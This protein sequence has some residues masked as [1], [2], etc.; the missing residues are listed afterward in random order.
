ME[1]TTL[2]ETKEQVVAR[3]QQLAENT[4]LPEK[5]EMDLLKQLFYRYHNQAMQEARQQYI[6][7]GGDPETYV[8][9]MDPQEETFRQAMQTLRERRAAEQLKI[10]QERADN[11]EKKLKILEQIQTLT[12]NPEDAGTHFDE[13]KQLQQ[14]WKETGAV[15]AERSTELWKNYQLYSEQYYDLLKMGHEL[16][17]YDFK[18]NLEIKT[19]LCEK[20]EALKDVEDVISAFNQL[21]ALHQQWKETGPVER[22]LRESLWQRFKD[23]ST[24]VNKRHQAHFEAIKAKEE[25]NLTKKTG[26]CEKIE[27]IIANLEEKPRWEDITKQVL[28]LQEEWRT[29][30]FAPQK[31]NTAIFERFRTACND[32]F[33]RKS[34]Y[35]KQIREALD[36]NLEKKKALLERALALKDSTEWTKTAQ[37][38]TQIQ[39]QWKEIGAVPKK[40]SEEIWH[41]FTEACDA[42]FQARKQAGAGQ[43]EEQEQNMQK[44][45]DIITQLKA[46][47]EEGAEVIMDTV[48]QLQQQWNE[49]GH[50]PFKEKDKLYA[51]YREVCDAIY[52][53]QRSNR[54]AGRAA[55]RIQR[56]ENAAGGDTQRLQRAYEQLKQEIKTY[57][58]NLGFLSSSSKKGNALVDQLTEKVAALKSELKTLEAKIQG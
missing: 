8:P 33:N 57:E 9:E 56:I 51:R 58:N 28:A 3:A 32:F 1:E 7:A 22:D 24:E 39:K 45:E 4:E 36:A 17:D 21:Q 42:F 52:G 23:A 16:R 38:L 44:K 18:K 47:T 5:A 37:E 27:E 40:Y 19:E 20:A 35:Y 12:A 55:A 29:I 43:H 2:F 25:E 11:L 46:M 34:E 50:V 41:Q 48:K 10:E 15:P 14:Q 53:S 26:L 30:G 6:D 13:Y 31:Q 49:I 54:A